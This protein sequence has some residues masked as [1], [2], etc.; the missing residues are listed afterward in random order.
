MP[1]E[2]REG[3]YFLKDRPGGFPGRSGKLAGQGASRTAARKS[4]RSAFASALPA[5]RGFR[6][7]L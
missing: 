6:Q 3:I 2:G 5:F 7:A 1:G 4:G